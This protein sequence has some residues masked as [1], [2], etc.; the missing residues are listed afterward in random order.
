MRHNKLVVDPQLQAINKT[1]QTETRLK[2][3]ES[4]FD[5]IKKSLFLDNIMY[6]K[7]LFY[8]VLCLITFNIVFE[9]ILLL[10]QSLKKCT[11]SKKNESSLSRK[12]LHQ[13]EVNYTKRLLKHHISKPISF[14]RNIFEKYIYKNHPDFRYPKQF[15]NT[16]IIAF[17]LLYYITCIIIR[18]SR[19]IVNL[20]SNVLVLIINFIFQSSTDSATSSFIT[21]SRSQLNVLIKSLFDHIARDIAIACMLTSGLYLIQLFL[22]IRNYQRHVLNAY[23]GVYVD[24][25][26]PKNFSNTK[27][28]SS[29]LHYR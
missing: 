18:K 1:H 23:K 13:H 9:F 8:A 25:P 10:K 24:I 4:D 14:S 12:S 26:S 16:Q 20:S 22:G 28:A 6:E 29:S 11:N 19:L 3:N 7:F 15:I 21:N 27:I 2:F 5:M 17:V